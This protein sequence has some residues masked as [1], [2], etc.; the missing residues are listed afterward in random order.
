MMSGRNGSFFMLM[1][2]VK[3][4]GST[5]ADMALLT[6]TAE[7]HHH[8]YGSSLIINALSSAYWVDDRQFSD[9]KHDASLIA[10]EHMQ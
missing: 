3:K 7:D 1:I 5:M 4:L 10:Q 8:A 6:I 9:H 2:L